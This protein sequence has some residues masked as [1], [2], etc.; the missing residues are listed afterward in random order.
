MRMIQ[1]D[2]LH[3]GP[4]LL[5]TP[6]QH[7]LSTRDDSPVRRTR[8][9]QVVPQEYDHAYS[10]PVVDIMVVE[11]HNVRYQASNHKIHI[12]T[13]TLGYFEIDCCSRNAHD[14]LLAFLQATIAPERVLDGGTAE[15]FIHP[16]SSAS[17]SCFDFDVDALNA[18]YMQGRVDRETWPEKFSRR[19]GKVVTSL[20]EISETLCAINCCEDS[21]STEEVREDP[22]THGLTYG[23]LEMD[24]C[25]QS[26]NPSPERMTT[27]KKESKAKLRYCHLPSGLSVEQDEVDAR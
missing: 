27:I 1:N 9:S 12:T 14:I 22:P 8:M 18:Q 26:T 17:T 2:K 21:A 23:D 6:I 11:T 3:Y 19:M 13:L 7:F 5:F 20:T 25:D 10:I 16:K 24:D 4:E 15:D